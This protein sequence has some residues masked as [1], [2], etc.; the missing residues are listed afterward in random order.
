MAQIRITPRARA[1]L[2]EIWSYIADDSVTNTDPLLT[3]C[4]KQF[5]RWLVSRGRDVAGK[6][7]L[8]EF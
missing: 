7:L 4:M 1:D 5:R 6:N 3:S 2:M 8:L